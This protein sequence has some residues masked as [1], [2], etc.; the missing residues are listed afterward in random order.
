MPILTKKGKRYYFAHVPKTAG[1][2]LYVWFYRNGYEIE[3]LSMHK[4][5]G[6]Y[7]SFNNEFMV[8]Q[9]KIKG[10]LANYRGSIQ[11]ATFDVWKN[12]GPFDGSFAIIRN[13]YSRYKSEIKFLFKSY[14]AGIA[15]KQTASELAC[16][17]SALY[18]K[19]KKDFNNDR[20]IFDNHIRPQ[21]EF[22][23]EDTRIFSFESNWADELAQYLDLTGEPPKENVSSKTVIDLTS[24]ETSLID[25]LYQAD[26]ACF[27][28]KKEE[29]V[30][31]IN[32][33]TY[34]LAQYAK[35][36]N[37]RWSTVFVLIVE[38]FRKSYWNIMKRLAKE[39]ANKYF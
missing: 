34:E 15:E 30:K 2:S 9:F 17:R 7:T 22:L 4:G 8:E 28:Y 12:W 6:T 38:E 32:S 5:F 33:E 1:T 23:D 3:N 18:K 25:E 16:F 29:H 13:P 19:I 26:F 39:K 20:S 31:S 14:C 11:H 27:E 35:Q 37:L 24:D 21:K 10:K 36:A